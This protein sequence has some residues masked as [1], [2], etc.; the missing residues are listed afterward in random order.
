MACTKEDKTALAHEL[1]PE[2]LRSS[3]KFQ[4]ADVAVLD[5]SKATSNIAILSGPT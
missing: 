4:I 2:R 5:P 1:T 3:V